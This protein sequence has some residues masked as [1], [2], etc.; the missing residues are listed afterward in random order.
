[1]TY[2]CRDPWFSFQFD[3]E[4]FRSFYP[5]VV[6][7]QDRKAKFQKVKVQKFR[8]FTIYFSL[9]YFGTSK[10]PFE[11]WEALKHASFC[12]EVTCS[13]F[14]LC[15]PFSICSSSWKGYLKDKKDKTTGKNNDTCIDFCSL[16]DLKRAE[17]TKDINFETKVS[18]FWTAKVEYNFFSQKT[19]ENFENCGHNFFTVHIFLV[20]KKN[21]FLGRNCEVRAKI[22]KMLIISLFK[23][24]F[25]Y[26]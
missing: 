13:N 1:M 26:L 12:K 4:I 6:K 8:K 25:L 24:K 16:R 22:V 10:E 15:F 19:L 17:N 7:K 3:I 14:D 21:R 11:Q 2:L 9:T 5:F 23:R 20:R 18:C